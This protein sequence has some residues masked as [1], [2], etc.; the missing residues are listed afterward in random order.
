MPL[1]RDEDIAKLAGIDDGKA[2]GWFLP[3]TYAWIKGES[4]FEVLKRAHAAMQKTLDK[5]W[6]AR[7]A[8]RTRTDCRRIFAPARVRHAPANRSNRYLWYRRPL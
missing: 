3:E 5:A 6:S 1:S 8:E 2:E 4:D 7:A